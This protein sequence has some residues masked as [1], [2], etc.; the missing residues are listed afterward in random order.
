MHPKQIRTIAAI[1]AWAVVALSLLACTSEEEGAPPEV[2][3]QPRPGPMHGATRPPDRVIDGSP[4]AVRAEIVRWFSQAGYQPFQ[5]TALVEHAKIE[6]GFNPCARAPGLRYTFQ[7]GGGR[8][9]KLLEFAGTAGTCPPLDKQ[10]AFADRELRNEAA[11]SCFWEAKTEPA[12][13]KALRRG[14][15]RGS[16]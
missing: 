12:A 5:V 6:S 2:V 13:L 16:C 15:G 4:N 3:L 10:L 8:L 14:F 7:W 9:R 1:A 11:Y